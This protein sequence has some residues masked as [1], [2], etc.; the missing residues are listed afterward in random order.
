MVEHPMESYLE[1]LLTNK[2]KIMILV[3]IIVM[4]T[5]VIVVITI[6]IVVI[7]IAIVVIIIAIHIVLI[8][9]ITPLLTHIPCTLVDH[10]F[11][12]PLYHWDP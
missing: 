6:A 12:H 10:Q 3:I 9:I 11:H 5:I 2:R 8:L 1:T 7:T 4:I